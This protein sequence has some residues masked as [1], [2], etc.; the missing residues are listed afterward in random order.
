MHPLIHRSLNSILPGYDAVTMGNRIPK[1]RCNVVPS[2]K[3]QYVLR[4][5]FC[6]GLTL[7]QWAR[8]CRRF[9]VTCSLFQGSPKSYDLGHYLASK[10]RDPITY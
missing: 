5:P 1:F 3:G 6:W 4:I 7:R 2:F 8:D 10:D 9:E